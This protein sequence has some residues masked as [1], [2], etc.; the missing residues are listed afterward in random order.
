MRAYVAVNFSRYR[1]ET[2]F[3]AHLSPDVVLPGFSTRCLSRSNRGTADK[4]IT[5]VFLSM[6]ADD[7]RASG[8]NPKAIVHANVISPLQAVPFN[9]RSAKRS[10]DKLERSSLEQTASFKK[11][12]L[13]DT[14]HKVHLDRLQHC[15][16][17]SVPK[18]SILCGDRRILRPLV[19]CDSGANLPST[20]RGSLSH[21]SL[22]GNA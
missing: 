12:C 19:L 17:F 13:R 8:G 2:V 18:T 7:A 4:Q 3:H 9:V 21:L 11:L 16:M 6:R 22:H 5:A 15:E 20:S 1:R 14:R 10:S